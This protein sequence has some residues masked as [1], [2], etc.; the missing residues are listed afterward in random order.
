MTTGTRHFAGRSDFAEPEE[1]PVFTAEEIRALLPFL[2]RQYERESFT[3]ELA[4]LES[5]IVSDLEARPPLCPACGWRAARHVATG[6]CVV[7]H[8]RKMTQAADD[9]ALEAEERRNYGAAK[10]RRTRARAAR[11]ERCEIS[12][13]PRSC[14]HRRECNRGN[15]PESW[16]RSLD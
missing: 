4:S 11:C 1:E 16:T 5:R 9:A 14:P 12:S 6:W 2:R 13:D 3:G 8:L 15:G 10:K 7:C